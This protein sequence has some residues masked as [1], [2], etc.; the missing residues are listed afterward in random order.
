MG[1]FYPPIARVGFYAI[2]YAVFAVTAQI[3]KEG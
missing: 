3:K 1:F 2:P